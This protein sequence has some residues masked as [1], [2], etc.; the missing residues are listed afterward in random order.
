MALQFKETDYF[1]H[2]PRCG[3]NYTRRVVSRLNVNGT[4][5]PARDRGH[6]HL[7]PLCVE[8]PVERSFCI[9]RTD[10]I[11]WYESFYR[12]RIHK[13]KEKRG[14]D[15]GHPLDFGMW[16]K[17]RGPVF[18][19]ETFLEH[20]LKRFPHGYVTAVYCQYAPFVDRVLFLDDLTS[21]LPAMFEEWG[22]DTPIALPPHNTNASPTDRDVLVPDELEARVLFAERGVIN[23]IK[24]LRNGKKQ[25]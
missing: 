1:F 6:G 8:T 24:E 18:S 13:H 25:I 23:Y 10:I 3:G 21:S 19:F 17:A 22:Y 9:L 14:Y 2:V 7:G 12:Y 11:G 5:V 15:A 4:R 16:E 20:A